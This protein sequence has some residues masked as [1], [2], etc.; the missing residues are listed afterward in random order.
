M[1]KSFLLANE[2][3]QNP[4]ELDGIYLHQIGRRHLPYGDRVLK[5]AQA[6]FELTV[7]T[8]GEGEVITNEVS[9]RVK[10]GDIYFSIPGDSHEIIPS[11]DSPLKFDFFAFSCS[12]PD[13]SEDLDFIAQNYFSPNNRVFH[14][15][16]VRQLVADG[17]AELNRERVYSTEMLKVICRQILIYIIRAFKKITPDKQLDTVTPAE[18][19]CYRLMNYIDTHIYSIKNLEDLSGVTDYSYGYLSA[20]FKKTTSQT[21]DHYYREKKMDVARLL[22]TENRYSITAISDMLGYS[23]VY[24]FS[25]AFTK[26]FGMSPR[27]YRNEE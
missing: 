14:A 1:E 6:L 19:L 15:E 18:V 5:H 20:L 26:R 17:F 8:E 11:K 9:T 22:I 16:R 4:L 27:H 21:L 7:V 10:S 23:S 3:Y 24:A 12:L 2:Y 13:F 25:K